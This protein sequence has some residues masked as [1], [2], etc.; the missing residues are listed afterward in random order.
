MCG[1]QGFKTHGPCKSGRVGKKDYDH[2]HCLKSD[3]WPPI[4]SSWISRCH[5]WPSPRVVDKIVRSGCHLV[6]IGHKYGN[7]VDNEWRIS[8]S[9][10]E[11]E[12]VFHM[13]QT[14]L[15]AY[16]LLKLF[17]TELI[18]KGLDDEEKLLCSYHIKTAVFW[19]IQQNTS[20]AWCP[21]NLLAGF[22]VC[23]KV[24][25]KW[26][27]EGFCPNFFI[28]ENNMFLNK[29]F[30]HAQA[31]L[32][33]RL[34][35]LYE[36]GFAFLLQSPSVGHCITSVLCNPR[37]SFCTDDHSL[38]SE[39]KFDMTFFENIFHHVT[40]DLFDNWESCEI[41]LHAG[42]QLI[43]CIV[44]P[45]QIIFLQDRMKNVLQTSA[46]M[47]HDSNTSAANKHM[48]ITDKISCYML[49]LAA[50]FGCASDMLYL[51]MYYYRTLRY[52]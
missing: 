5:T 6:P 28:P 36:N 23:F 49:K 37:I 40:I 34:W 33:A 35:S 15:L 38:I 24:I 11:T 50:K 4:A 41:Y 44:K 21:S 10:A 27:Y 47:L 45:C 12:L 1:T 22:W 2:A 29:V 17:L 20:F 7:Q 51:A 13:N 43:W 26:V 52:S 42:E 16:G 39:A 3:F 18:N 48:Y 19:A 32:F 46:F 31:I 30:G 25:L 8:F 9:K 14:Q